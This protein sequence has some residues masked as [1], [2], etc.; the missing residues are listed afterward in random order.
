MAF[1]EPPALA[2]ALEHAEPSAPT[3]CTGWT[4]HD[5]AAHLAAGAKEMADLIEEHLAGL[6]PRATQGYEARERPFPGSGPRRAAGPHGRA[7]AS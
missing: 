6:R 7:L 2:A 5:I 4:A 3:A 1:R